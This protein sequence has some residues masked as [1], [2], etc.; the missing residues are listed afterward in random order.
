MGLAIILLI[1]GLIFRAIF[2]I[3]IYLIAFLFIGVLAIKIIGFVMGSV[4]MLC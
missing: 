1:I 2:K 4:I 3:V